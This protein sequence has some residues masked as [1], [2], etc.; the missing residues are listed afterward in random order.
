MF[1]FSQTLQNVL[2]YTEITKVKWKYNFK[3]NVIASTLSFIPY[4]WTRKVFI[5]CKYPERKK[6]I[7]LFSPASPSSEEFNLLRTT[8]QALNVTHEPGPEGKLNED[9]R[10][11]PQIIHG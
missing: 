5:S 4:Q 8:K 6:I 10:S 7:K 2:R 1:Y 11:P 3:H 9:F